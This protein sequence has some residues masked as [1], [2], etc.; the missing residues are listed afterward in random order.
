MTPTAALTTLLATLVRVRAAE[1]DYALSGDDWTGDCASGINQSPVNLDTYS[2]VRFTFE[3]E[4]SE[5]P[6]PDS[7]YVVNNGLTMVYVPNTDGAV[8]ILNPMDGDEE[9]T[10][11]QFHCHWDTTASRYS[12]GSE[13]KL[14]GQSYPLECHFVHYRTTYGDL[15]EAV[16][17][18]DGLMV[19]GQF[20]E[21]DDTAVNTELDKFLNAA[22]N[23]IAKDAEYR[24]TEDLAITPLVTSNSEVFAYSGSLTT[25]TC[26][27]VVQWFVFRTPMGVPMAQLQKLWAL[28]K[29]NTS[30]TIVHNWRPTQA[31]NGRTVHRNFPYEQDET[32]DVDD[33][34][35]LSGARTARPFALSPVI[36]ISIY[37]IGSRGI[38]A[39]FL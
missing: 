18:A 19:V 8:T 11:A 4:F 36:F 38:T 25:P 37:V 33:G 39:L 22:E 16:T 13:H 31:L 26:N 30:A 21:I 5:R 7:G 2:A 32:G 6:T 20:Y 27:E 24:L 29:D 10:L 15:G 23:V 35:E 28:E 3:I 17:H 1:W 34:H 12:I 9:Y 14:D